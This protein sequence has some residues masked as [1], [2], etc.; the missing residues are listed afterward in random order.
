MEDEAAHYRKVALLGK[1]EETLKRFDEVETV[2]EKATTKKSALEE[3]KQAQLEL[4]EKQEQAM[5]EVRAML[6]KA[7]EDLAQTEG[8]Y[9]EEKAKQGEPKDLFDLI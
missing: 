6:K 9:A 3:Q 5:K 8:K 1:A 2:L 7:D 4:L